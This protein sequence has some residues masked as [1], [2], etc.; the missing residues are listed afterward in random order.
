MM[1]GVWRFQEVGVGMAGT[2]LHCRL[3]VTERPL[4]STSGDCHLVSGLGT[5]GVLKQHFFSG[6]KADRSWI[7]NI[8]FT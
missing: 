2:I 8:S 1:G 7:S 6:T 3:I 4:L 5:V